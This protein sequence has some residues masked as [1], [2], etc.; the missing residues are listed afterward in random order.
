H[1]KAVKDESTDELDS[2][3]TILVDFWIYL[4]YPENSRQRFIE[5]L[6][7]FYAND[8]SKLNYLQEFEQDYRMENAVQW[9]T[10]DTFLYE[11]LNRA[12]RQHKIEQLFLYGFF[13]QDLHQQLDSEHYNQ[14]NNIHTFT[15]YRGQFLSR[16]EIESLTSRS[17]H[18]PFD[19]SVIVNTS[20]LSTT[21]DRRVASIY[22][23]KQI[24]PDND[25]QSVLFQINVDM[26]TKSRP[27]ANIA[28]LSYF[29][30]ES[31]ILFMVGTWFEIRE[32]GVYYNKNEHIWI[33]ELELFKREINNVGYEDDLKSSDFRVNLRRCITLLPYA[34]K[35]YL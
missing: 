3:W 16:N 13:L 24:D 32:N 1:F 21:L 19:G 23:N 29:D 11:S 12:L 30:S 35:K 8:K 2:S 27:F 28:H 9:Y 17:Y 26:K 10:R 5:S 6:K 4:P 18:L 15:C 7:I 14:Q 25:I 20:L 34:M 31:E 22:L 33:I